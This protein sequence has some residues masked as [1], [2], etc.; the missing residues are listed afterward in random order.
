MK[1]RWNFSET[2]NKVN[3]D[4][5]LVKKDIVILL[6]GASGLGGKNIRSN[7]KVDSDAAWYSRTFCRQFYKVYSEIKDVKESLHI[8][9]D[10]LYDE[11]Q[12][13]SKLKD[14]P[15]HIFP[16][17]TGTI[18]EFKD[19][20]ANFFCL[21]DIRTLIRTKEDEIKKIGDYRLEALDQSVF[22]KAS[23]MSKTNSEP[24]R[25]SLSKIRNMIIGNR[26]KMNTPEGYYI[27]SFD[28]EA[29]ENMVEES[30]EI[31][32]IKELVLMS[33]GFYTIFDNVS[34]E[35][36]EELKSFRSH[37]DMKHKIRMILSRDKDY[38]TYQRFKL[39]DDMS[40]IFLENK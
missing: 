29:I 1:T 16:S 40:L 30:I 25:V 7:K 27:F 8:T 33:D 37:A 34:I 39:I 9:L 35:L 14:P 15:P 24:F 12:S 19:G 31:P 20:Y 21:G 17:A 10:M 13:R 38:E 36:F 4:R 32:K 5:T 28:H 26:Q 23:E 3:D 2:G 18:V 6:D 11:F 22:D